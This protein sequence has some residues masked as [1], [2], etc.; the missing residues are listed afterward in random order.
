[1]DVESVLFAVGKSFGLFAVFLTTQHGQHLLVDKRFVSKFG[2]SLFTKTIFFS[3][4]HI[5][6]MLEHKVFARTRRSHQ[7]DRASFLD[8]FHHDL[9]G[10]YMFVEQ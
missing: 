10:N 5:E 7:E 1:M 8:I 9:Y 3:R 6:H 2:A 4:Q